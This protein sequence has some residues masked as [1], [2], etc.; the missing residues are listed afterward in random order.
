VAGLRFEAMCMRVRARA[1]VVQH[2]RLLVRL[3]HQAR[4]ATSAGGSGSRMLRIVPPPR[5]QVGSSLYKHSQGQLD[6]ICTSI[7]GF[8]F[9]NQPCNLIARTDGWR[10][11]YFPQ[12]NPATC[13]RV[14]NVTD[15]C[16]IIAPWWLQ[17]NATYQGQAVVNG[18]LSDGWMKVRRQRAARACAHRCTSSH[19]PPTARP[20]SKAAR[21][22]TPG[23]WRARRS[24]AATTRA[25]PPSR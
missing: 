6:E 15:Y 21:R 4:E 25:T 14:C 16:G 18:V 7:V 23:S 1:Q 5:A 19:L 13:C 12:S 22:T 3:D 9:S 11:V 2:G 20:C 10:Y 24:P 8:E 17:Q